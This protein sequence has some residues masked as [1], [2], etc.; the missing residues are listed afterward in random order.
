VLQWALQFNHCRSACQIVLYAFHATTKQRGGE[1]R[2]CLALPPE[3]FQWAV[4]LPLCVLPCHDVLWC[5]AHCVVL[6]RAVL[7]HA[8]LCSAVL[9]HQI[10]AGALV[11][12]GDDEADGTA[13]A[14]GNARSWIKVELMLEEVRSRG[15]GGGE[16][17][18]GQALGG[19]CWSG[20]S[21]CG[22]VC[23]V[24][25]GEKVCEGGRLKNGGG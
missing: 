25:R 12:G 17:G 21:W 15:W 4:V 23:G 19:E 3:A 9:C 24:Q 6:C 13:A 8:V 14:E 10:V 2:G 16:R 7:C 20:D 18:G 1:G 22:R 11:E 5:A